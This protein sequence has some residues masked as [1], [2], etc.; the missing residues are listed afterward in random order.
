MPTD[1]YS[2][3]ETNA[4]S[5]RSSDA[6]T[7]AASAYLVACLR[8]REDAA[9]KP[10]LPTGHGTW[11]EIGDFADDTAG[12][13]D[14][15]F[16]VWTTIAGATPG[17]ASVDLTL[18]EATNGSHFHVVEFTA[19]EVD[20]SG[21]VPS[22]VVVGAA[23]T[24]AALSIDLG[25]FADPANIGLAFIGNQVNEVLTAADGTAVGESSGNQPNSALLAV[26]G[27][28]NQTLA[29]TGTD[30]SSAAIGFE[31][32]A[33]AAG[34]TTLTNAGGIT[35]G[36]TFGEPRVLRVLA[37]TG[38]IPS[39]VA[40]GEPRLLRVL[41][42]AGGISSEE[43]FGEPRLLRV[44]GSVGAIETGEAFEIATVSFHSDIEAAGGIASLEAFGVP[45]LVR[46]LANAGQIVTGETF[47][48]ARAL[49]VLS[50]AGAIPSRET[51]SEPRLIRV[52]IPSS[53]PSAETFGTVRVLRV[54]RA[55]NITTGETFGTAAVTEVAPDEGTIYGAVILSD[56]ARFQVL[57]SDGETWLVSVQDLLL[58][59]VTVGDPG[60]QARLSD[61][62]RFDV[63]I[64]DLLGG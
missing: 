28:G 19:A 55:V 56:R 42:G 12:A 32:T 39:A 13:T 23:V 64:A 4:H 38:A 48:T 47:G 58:A 46:V 26:Y 27:V 30:S 6:F 20:T 41:L 61:Q 22:G 49:R 36:E 14:S 5:T 53:I 2:V 3:W 43:A 50:S 33:A 11:E 24:A 34:G 16:T 8:N 60:Y 37:N 29:A 25:A 63:K 62:G 9:T 51:F 7:P 35:T 45:T 18:G 40:F 31:L 54:L 10:G 15:R 52:L 59:D 17:S 44:L 1:R 21:G 57:V